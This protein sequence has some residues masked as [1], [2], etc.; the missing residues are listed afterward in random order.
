M[1]GTSRRGGGR[2]RVRVARRASVNAMAPAWAWSRLQPVRV[3]GV[4]LGLLTGLTCVVATMQPAHAIRCWRPSPAEHIARLPM[5]FYARVLAQPHAASRRVANGE[6]RRIAYLQ[7]L[8]TYKGV[9]APIVRVGYVAPG[10]RGGS[11]GG[12]RFRAGDLMMVFA[13][14]VRDADDID[15]VVRHCD[16]APFHH[17]PALR[18][19]Y[20]RTL[21]KR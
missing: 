9:T 13:R 7:V 20:W 18:P 4:A 19:A 8:E 1:S 5:V 16:M 3:I 11:G 10:S 17:R 15:A 2:G 14:P 12:W 21:L 6:A